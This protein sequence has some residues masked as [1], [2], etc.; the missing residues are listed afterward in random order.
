MKHVCFEVFVC[1]YV[2]DITRNNLSYGSDGLYCATAMHTSRSES[3][4]RLLWM[5]INTKFDWTK[6]NSRGCFP[7]RLIDVSCSSGYF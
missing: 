3:A 6:K 7:A 4:F 1:A 2:F 5:I